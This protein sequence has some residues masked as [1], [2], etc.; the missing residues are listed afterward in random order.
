MV[1]VSAALAA[2]AV[3]TRA[4]R[5]HSP[6]AAAATPS[7][8]AITATTDSAPHPPPGVSSAPYHGVYVFR[9]K[10]PALAIDAGV[11]AVGTDGQGHV[12][13][14]ASIWDAAWY[15]YGPAPGQPGDAVI[16]GH[17]DWYTGPALFEHLAQLKPGDLVEV[18][19]GATTIEFKVSAL[20]W[21]PYTSPPPGFLASAGPPRLSLVTCGGSWNSRAGTYSERLVVDALLV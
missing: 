4:V 9:L 3:V 11:E 21:F 16:D 8:P 20:N 1:A 17:L 10:I 18:I 14:P 5:G 15:R 2:H 12:G 7:L 13:V 6:A 19:A